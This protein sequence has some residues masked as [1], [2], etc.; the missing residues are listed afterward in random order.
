M[1]LNPK[2]KKEILFPKIIRGFED[3]PDEAPM[4]YGEKKHG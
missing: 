3:G 2:L 1:E 4:I